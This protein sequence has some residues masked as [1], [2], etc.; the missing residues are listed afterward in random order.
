[1]PQEN[2]W[3][4]GILRRRKKPAESLQIL[5]VERATLDIEYHSFYSLGIFALTDSQK[6]SN[7]YRTCIQ[8]NDDKSIIEWNKVPS[9]HTTYLLQHISTN[10]LAIWNTTQGGSDYSVPVFDGYNIVIKP[11]D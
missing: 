10:R 4:P 6:N 3:I 5:K 9:K 11:T 8:K 7:A 2:P 1:M